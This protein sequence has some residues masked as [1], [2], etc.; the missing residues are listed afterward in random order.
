L[1][2]EEWEPIYLEIVKEMGYSIEKDLTAAYTLSHLITDRALTTEELREEL[3]ERKTAVVFGAGPSLK[4][5]IEEFVKSGIIDDVVVFVADGASRAF[6]ERGLKI[7][8]IVTDLDG[9]DETLIESSRVCLATVV[10]AHGDNIEK[11]RELVP[12]L[13]GKI[14]GTTQCKPCDLLY[15]FG[16]FTDGDRAVFLSDAL[17]FEN[18][19]LAGMDFGEEIGEYSKSINKHDF[20]RLKVKRKKL[21]IGKKLLEI[22]ASKSTRKLFNATSRGEEIKGFIQTSFEEIEDVL[23]QHV[24]ES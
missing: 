8:I 20:E 9:G 5:D 7:D 23:R 21:R 1:R 2:W 14:L 17:G 24:L 3:D 19:V 16:G 18:I 4:V 10:H 22:Y 11:I 6:L 15:N 13:Y 12:R